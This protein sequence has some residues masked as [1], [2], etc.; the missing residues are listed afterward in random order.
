VFIFR[1]FIVIVIHIIVLP[2][3]TQ[4]GEIGS[5][6]P[7]PM[8]AKGLVDNH[9]C[10]LLSIK[11]TL[12]IRNKKCS[13]KVTAV[14]RPQR[15]RTRGQLVV[16]RTDS[17]QEVQDRRISSHLLLLLLLLSITGENPPNTTT[18]YRGRSA[19]YYYRYYRY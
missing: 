19:Y 1:R 8:L 3:S 10:I 2:S 16:Y 6:Y 5:V 13:Q 12:G 14:P 4:V 15:A 17:G 7:T 9:E 11:N 18:Y